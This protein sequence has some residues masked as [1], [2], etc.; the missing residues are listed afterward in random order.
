MI[1][2]KN[3]ISVIVETLHATSLRHATSLGHATPLR[4]RFHKL[5]IWIIILIL[6]CTYLHANDITR[7][8]GSAESYGRGMVS[9]SLGNSASDMM[10][11]PATIGLSNRWQV[12]STYSKYLSDYD[13]LQVGGMYPVGKH[14]FGFSYF[15]RSFGE[16]YLFPATGVFDPITGYPDFSLADEITYGERILALNYAYS[17]IDNH[18]ESGAAFGITYKMIYLDTGGEIDD[19]AIGGDI[20]VGFKFVAGPFRFGITGRNLVHLDEDNPNSL[21]SLSWGAG[22]FYEEIPTTVQAGF[23]LGLFNNRF[24]IGIDG[25]TPEEG[26]EQISVY[27]LG[28]EWWIDEHVALRAGIPKYYDN[29]EFF[30]QDPVLTRAVFGIG[31]RTIYVNV[32]YAWYPNP[33]IEELH[34]HFLTVSLHDPTEQDKEWEE[35]IQ[36]KKTKKRIYLEGD[37]SE[38]VTD[39]IYTLKGNVKHV[40]VVNVNEKKYPLEKSQ[41]EIEISLKPGINHIIVRDGEDE[42]RKDKEIIY[43][44]PIES[45]NKQYA[46]YKKMI[47]W[48]AINAGLHT[49][50]NEDFAKPVT[51]ENL[52]RILTKIMAIEIPTEV[53]NELDLDTPLARYHYAGYFYNYPNG[54][55]HGE[56]L[57][58]RRDLAFVAYQI[59]KNNHTIKQIP[60]E[61]YEEITKSLKLLDKYTPSE[62]AHPETVPTLYDILHVISKMPAVD[63]HIKRRFSKYGY[64][65]TTSATPVKVDEKIPIYVFSSKKLKKVEVQVNNQYPIVLKKYG[66]YYFAKTINDQATEKVWIK[67]TMTTKDDRTIVEEF[68]VTDISKGITNQSL[69]KQLHK[70]YIPREK[71]KIEK[72]EGREK[73]RFDITVKDITGCIAITAVFPDRTNIKFK[74]IL[75]RWY[76]SK[77]VIN[78]I[79]KKSPYLKMYF[80]TKMGEIIVKKFKINLD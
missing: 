65:Y 60:S 9:Q 68:F 35:E 44:A 31:L 1:I 56:K 75:D 66:E 49:I 30:D 55:L 25:E 73:T 20:D 61:T 19:S 2:R 38:I 27:R 14:R 69:Q 47:L 40:E 23:G 64:S 63:E 13:W 76:G 6:L 5:P 10:L 59:E 54:K 67:V 53:E 58:N 51:R 33:E 77:T 4:L 42:V 17:M 78:E 80:K 62:F 72:I 41:F 70:V 12:Y 52:A 50:K 3:N 36:S 32:D 22:D 28:I 15:T 71:I 11:N 46:G 26:D 39:R 45:I 37:T 48:R 74:K 79:I 21:G 24:L 7:W 29:D 8:L 34:S 43:I 57:V 16:V 18:Y